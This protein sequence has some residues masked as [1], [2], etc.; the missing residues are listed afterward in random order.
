MK[1]LFGV[2]SII[3]AVILFS[4][5]NAHQT[6]L[7]KIRA[8]IDGK[9]LIIQSLTIQID[10]IQKLIY[11]DS[12]FIQSLKTKLD[13]AEHTRIA[14]RK[15]WEKQIYDAKNS[16]AVHAVADFWQLTGD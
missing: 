4:Y 12:I 7:N 15:Y 16:T 3:L 14:E 10:S 2:L 1:Y 6:D 8:E 9:E 5:L 11:E 13:V